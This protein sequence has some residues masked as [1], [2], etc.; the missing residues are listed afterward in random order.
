[1]KWQTDRADFFKTERRAIRRAFPDAE[2]S[3]RDGFIVLQGHFPVHDNNGNEV[4]R[5]ELR[6]VFPSNYPDQIPIVLV[7]D[8]RIPAE[9]QRHVFPESKTACLC[10]PH[11]VPLYLSEID[12]M[13]FWEKLLKFWVVGQAEYDRTGKWPFP[14]RSHDKSAIY[15]GFS[16]LLG[17]PDR[18]TAQRFTSL[19]LRKNPAKGHELCPCG[20][21]LK[22]RDC[23]QPEYQRL[24]SLLTPDVLKMYRKHL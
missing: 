23:H 2:L 17:T 10:L 9:V 19:L 15:D 20:S 21:G 12:F 5:Y 4:D 16:E 7:A 22:L 3:E 24:R 6:I 13:G 1:M 11:E 18:D 8:K 14:E